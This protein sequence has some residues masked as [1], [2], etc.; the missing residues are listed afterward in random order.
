MINV[1]CFLATMIEANVSIVI[2]VLGTVFG[3][4]S[5]AAFQRVVPSYVRNINDVLAVLNTRSNID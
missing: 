2:F 3:A 5:L 4:M 1:A